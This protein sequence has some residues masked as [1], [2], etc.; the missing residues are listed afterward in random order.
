[1][2]KFKHLIWESESAEDVIGEMH[3]L[4]RNTSYYTRKRKYESEEVKRI[5]RAAC[6]MIHMFANRLERALTRQMKNISRK[7]YGYGRKA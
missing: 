1:M 3:R 6:G 7:G 2:G 5:K 4:A